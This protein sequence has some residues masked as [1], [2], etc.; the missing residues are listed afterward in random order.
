MT[1]DVKPRGT[2]EFY[3]S[4]QKAELEALFHELVDGSGIEEYIFRPSI[5]GGRDAPALINDVVKRFQLGGRL[6]LE[7]D[8]IRVIPGASPVIPEAGTSFQL[9]HHDDCA[10]ALLAAIEGRGAPGIYNLAGDG[11]VTMTDIA[12]ELGWRT[13][14]MPGLA[15]KAV[16]GLVTRLGRL[17]PQEL[18]WVNVARRS[19]IMDTAKA[20]RELGWRPRH[21]AAETM[22]ETIAGAK[23][24]GII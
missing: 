1:E 20:R 11:V 22:R 12:R 2:E 9:V 17:L 13:V 21:D 18:A 4:A 3:Y 5:V 23:A 7:R 10:D 15:V 24:A 6:P 19:V 14:P 16:V 8:L